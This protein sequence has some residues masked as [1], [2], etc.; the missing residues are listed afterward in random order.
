MYNSAT[1]GHLYTDHSVA[2]IESF[3]NAAAATMPEA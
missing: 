2:Y 1:A 3:G